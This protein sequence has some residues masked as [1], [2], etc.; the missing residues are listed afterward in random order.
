MFLIV[1]L[2]ACDSTATVKGTVTVETNTPPT[3]SIMTPVGGDISPIF[4]TVPC[5]GMVYDEIESLSSDTYVWL[6]DEVEIGRGAVASSGE[7]SGSFTLT[8]YEQHVL[9]LRVNDQ[10]GIMASDY[11]LVDAG[12]APDSDGDG[13]EDSV[14]C[15]PTNSELYLM[16]SWYPDEDQDGYGSTTGFQSCGPW[17][18]YVTDPSLA[19]DC[20]DRRG[21]THPG[22]SEVCN[23]RDDD[24][25]GTVDN[26]AVDAQTWYTDSDGDGWGD[27]ST[28]KVRCT[29]IAGDVA[30]SGDCDDSDRPSIRGRRN[31]AEALRIWTV[32]G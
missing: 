26:Q 3:V 16:G 9:Q 2:Q 31:I 15:N 18:G 14:D 29:S 12:E 17:D 27:S 19:T 13:V 22:A 23:G 8:D 1:L 28:A 11:V 21:D 10:S 7:V 20:N 5:T 30:A 4:T 25:D 6:L 32:M 24:C